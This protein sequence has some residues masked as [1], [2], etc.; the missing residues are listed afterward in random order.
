MTSKDLRI[1]K[2]MKTTSD[3]IS[4]HHEDEVTGKFFVVVTN[5]KFYLKKP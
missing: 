3:V 4:C 1:R 5:V 2:K